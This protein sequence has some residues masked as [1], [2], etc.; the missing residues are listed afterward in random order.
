MKKL[1]LLLV[2]LLPV[3]LYG[4]KT[5][6]SEAEKEILNKFDIPQDDFRGIIFSVDAKKC[7]ISSENALQGLELFFKSNEARDLTTICISNNEK[8]L[9]PINSAIDIKSA[10]KYYIELTEEL[11]K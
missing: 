6:W 2:A 5:E 8:A 3:F 4:Q 10:V 1:I 11:N 9:V 7:D